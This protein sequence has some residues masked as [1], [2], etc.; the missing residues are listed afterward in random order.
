MWREEINGR[1]EEGWLAFLFD[2]LHPSHTC[3]TCPSFVGGVR[4][5]F[6]TATP[7]KAR[8]GSRMGLPPRLPRGCCGV[9]WSTHTVDVAVAGIDLYLVA[10]I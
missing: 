3:E 4:C 8:V 7:I 2:G 6:L 9:T 10:V 5:R 1:K